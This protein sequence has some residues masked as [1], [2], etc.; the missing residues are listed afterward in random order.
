MKITLLFHLANS[1]AGWDF[2][3]V[4]IIL[5]SPWISWTTHLIHK[6]TPTARGVEKSDQKVFNRE[7]AKPKR[8]L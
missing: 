2:G 5:T 3:N 1:I 8:G 6:H 7:T 4:R